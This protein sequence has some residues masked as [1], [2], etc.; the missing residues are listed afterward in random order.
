M[1]SEICCNLWG[2]LAGDKLR[3]SRVHFFSF[4]VDRPFWDKFEI[5]DYFEMIWKFMSLNKIL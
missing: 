2:I 3:E 1:K 5:Q 4:M